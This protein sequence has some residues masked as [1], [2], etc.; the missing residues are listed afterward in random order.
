MLLIFFIHAQ[1]SFYFK[2]SYH[3]HKPN[4][5]NFK[6]QLTLL[7]QKKLSV[8]ICN[9]TLTKQALHLFFQFNDLL[10]NLFLSHRQCL[11][12]S[13]KT[14]FHTRLSRTT[15][16]KYVIVPCLQIS[17][18]QYVAILFIDISIQI[19]CNDI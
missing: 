3:L 12:P 17:I 6:N 18:F 5:A 7:F 10:S 19:C 4:I 13:A 9:L 1:Y 14:A 16:N 15:T 11:I 8:N 2:K